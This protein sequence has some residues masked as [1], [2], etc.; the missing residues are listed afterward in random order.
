MAKNREKLA[1]L[2]GAHKC[3]MSAVVPLAWPGW[4]R[5]CTSG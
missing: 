3:P 4:H 5:S 1:Q 2:L